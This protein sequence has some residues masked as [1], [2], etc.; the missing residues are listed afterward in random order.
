MLQVRILLF[1]EATNS[2]YSYT[3]VECPLQQYWFSQ[4]VEK[5]RKQWKHLQQPLTS[6]YQAQYSHCELA[7]HDNKRGLKFIKV[8]IIIGRPTTVLDLNPFKGYFSQIGNGRV[9]A[10][11]DF[12][13]I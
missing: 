6:T 3:R 1:S 4:S 2:V 12:V 11:D 13:L 10:R 8:E 9:R 7:I 5:Q